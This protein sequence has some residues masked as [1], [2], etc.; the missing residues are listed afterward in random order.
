MTTNFTEHFATAL[1]QHIEKSA[2][3]MLQQTIQSAEFTAKLTAS[4]GVEEL[5]QPLLLAIEQEMQNSIKEM[6]DKHLALS[7]QVQ[8]EQET[9]AQILAFMQ[10]I[11][12]RHQ[13]EIDQIQ[14]KQKEASQTNPVLQALQ[15]QNIALQ[16]QLEDAHRKIR[17]LEKENLAFRTETSNN[18][19]FFIER[20]EQ[21]QEQMDNLQKKM[22]S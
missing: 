9:N 6:A 3:D 14:N 1:Q 7:S 13:E 19:I 5:V 12:E 22:R 17:N 8:E 18:R 2:V 16:E 4:I 21:L 15:Q 10:D 20:Y 11:L